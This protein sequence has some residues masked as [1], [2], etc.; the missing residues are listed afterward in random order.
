MGCDPGLVLRWGLLVPT[1][2]LVSRARHCHICVPLPLCF[3]GH[4]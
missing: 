4:S 3:S 2:L 1:D